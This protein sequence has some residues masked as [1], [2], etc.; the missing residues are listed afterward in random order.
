LH[1]TRE[2]SVGE[3]IAKYPEAVEVMMRHGL[4]CVGCHFNPM[5]TLEGGS[6]LHGI[7]AQEIE[8]MLEEINQVVEERQQTFSNSDKLVDLTPKAAEKIVSIM[9]SEGKTGHVLRVAL[10]RGGCAGHSYYMEFE[11][12]PAQEDLVEESNG[13]KV[14]V[15]KQ[16]ADNVR[17]TVIDYQETLNS[18]G[19]SMRNPNAK[20]ACGCGQSFSV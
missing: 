1:V 4:H 7:P 3:I 20:R 19:F 16:I 9:N 10:I 12:T 17:G 13:L 18:S 6:K 2:M 15:S 8:E 5:D 14:I 11:E